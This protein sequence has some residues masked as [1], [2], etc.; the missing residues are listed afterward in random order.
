MRCTSTLVITTVSLNAIGDL[1]RIGLALDG[2]GFELGP[3]Q[4]GQQHGRQNANDRN[5]N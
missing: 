3:C 1:L 2:L 5:D 4:H